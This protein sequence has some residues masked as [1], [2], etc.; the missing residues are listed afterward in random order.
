MKKIFLPFFCMAVLISNAQFSRLIIGTYDS[1][2]SEGIYVYSFNQAD[3]SAK[4][5]GHVKTSN[6][7]FITVSP[8]KKYVYAVNE[9]AD[10]N[11][12][13]GG[14]SSFAFNRKNDML[15]FKN[16]H[17][18]EGNHPCYI[19]ADKTG[20]WIIAGNYSSG[21]FAILPVKKKGLL[22]K[23]TQVIQHDGN[24]PDT[25]RQ[26]TSHVHATI[27]SADNKNLFVTN[28]GTDKIMRYDFNEKTGRVIPSLQKF[29]STE[30]GSGPRHIDISNNGKYIYLLQELTGRLSVFSKIQNEF[31]IVQTVSTL[32][33]LYTGVAGSADIHITT[34]GKF[35]YASNRGSSNSIAIFSISKS[36]GELKLISHQSTLGL[37]PR[38]FNLDPTGNFLLVANQ[39]S[40]EVVIFKRDPDTG[41]LKDTGNKIKIGKPVCIKWL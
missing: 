6:P 37:T 12:K 27:L 25:V 5:L 11:G 15:V 26:K 20:K 4:E 31:K 40:N 21:N 9:N 10:K 33:A 41:L 22:G 17:S 36:N 14:V 29:I 30:G 19:T 35:L 13:G 8:N 1:H 34:D 24:G 39:N 32:P 3:G 23:A 2:T 28:L 18:S 7:S 38:N 16:Q